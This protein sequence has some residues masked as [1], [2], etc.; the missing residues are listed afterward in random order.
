[1]RIQK[2]PHEPKV[3]MDYCK[4][5]HSKEIHNDEEVQLMFEKFSNIVEEK[6]E[7]ILN[8]IISN[9]L[10]LKSLGRLRK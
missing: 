10:K 8:E 5:N 6:N 7:K 2:A 1:M 3:F 9:S 4:V